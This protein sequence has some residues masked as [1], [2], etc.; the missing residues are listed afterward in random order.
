MSFQKADVKS[1]K[2]K[3][4]S[5]IREKAEKDIILKRAE[6]ISQT[7]FTLIQLSPIL[8]GTYINA[9]TIEVGGIRIREPD[10]NLFPIKDMIPG[11][12]VKDYA[13]R[14]F[15]S[16]EYDIALNT[17][18]TSSITIIMPSDI[19]YWG[20]DYVEP[21]YFVYK[22]ASRIMESY[23]NNGSNDI[24]DFNSFIMSL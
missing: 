13:Y 23:L 3:L 24:N 5:K 9:H 15:I 17:P 2:N 4:K 14:S 1:F 22:N 18:L 10:I 6:T 21:T 11:S 16:K 12:I 8:T 7:V 20:S 19:V